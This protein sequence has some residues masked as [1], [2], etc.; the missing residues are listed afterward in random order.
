MRAAK[1][2]AVLAVFATALLP[3]TGVGEEPGSYAPYDGHNPF[4]CEVQ[5]V[6][7]GTDF[8]H[9]DADPFCVEFDKTQ[10]NV[11]DFGLAD[12][13]SK[14]PA[15]TAAASDKCFYYQHDHWTGS[16]VQGGQP[17]AWHWDGSYFFD[18]AHALG[19]VYVTNFRIGGQPADFTPYAP[20]EMQP[21]LAPGGGGGVL[22]T[23]DVE[24]D[25]TCVGKVDSPLEQ[26]FVYYH[27][28]VGGKI[29]RKRITPVRLRT[30]R[31]AVI[32][33]LGPAHRRADHTDRW[34]V[35][36]GGEMAIAWRGTALDRRVA[37][38]LTTSPGHRRGRVHPGV[39]GRL[40]RRLLHGKL[41]FGVSGYRTF[42]A[43][44]RARSRML[45]GIRKGKL[46]WIAVLDPHRVAGKGLR[47]TL[48]NLLARA[49]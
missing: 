45:F 26:R 44:R 29:F 16:I 24:A 30:L 6:G 37:A 20:P 14:E 42:E 15:R 11:T 25:P 49:A 9:P 21:Y 4:N 41:A 28:V 8:P 1:I 19:G 2:A 17:E 10:Q 38:L 39:R 12:F 7:T 32:R 18:K 40:A 27:R 47:T 48:A 46:A 43:P 23:G 35:T 34:D 5:N 13:L 31:A 36:G 3:A 33:R 22:L